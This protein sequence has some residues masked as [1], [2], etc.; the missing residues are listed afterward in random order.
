MLLL[1]GATVVA[2]MK[3]KKARDKAIKDMTPQPLGDGEDS[4]FADP[5]ADGF[6]AQDEVD[7]FEAEHGEF[8]SF[9]EEKQ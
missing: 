3:E 8:A 9:D 4:S 5:S 1:I 7:A 2:A 6:G